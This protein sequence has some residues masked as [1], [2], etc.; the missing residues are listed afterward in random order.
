MI[1]LGMVNKTHS[2][3]CVLLNSVKE[4]IIKEA[5][6]LLTY[7]YTWRYL[8]DLHNQLVSIN[9]IIA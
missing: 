3:N 9:S 8:H 7:V 1:I 2:E 4:F 6:Q 5:W